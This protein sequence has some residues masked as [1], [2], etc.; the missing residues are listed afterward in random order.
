M[1]FILLQLAILVSGTCLAQG[2]PP[3]QKFPKVPLRLHMA[4][5][6][7]FPEV[8]QPGLPNDKVVTLGEITSLLKDMDKSQPLVA[9]VTPQSKFLG[10]LP[11][12]NSAF[13]LPQDN[14][15]CIV[16]NENATVPMPNISNMPTLPYKYKGPGAIPNPSVPILLNKNTSKKK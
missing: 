7:K 13:A 9:L 2:V 14:M 10:V 15:P 4:P 3:E 8:Y 16:P 1:K 11:N 12:G 6:P 5:A